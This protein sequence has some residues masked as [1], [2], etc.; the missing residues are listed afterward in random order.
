MRITFDL[1]TDAAERLEA[2]AKKC[3]DDEEKVDSANKPH[4]EL[5]DLGIKSLQFQGNQVSCDENYKM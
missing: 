3:L 2:F 1:P 4:Y 5:L